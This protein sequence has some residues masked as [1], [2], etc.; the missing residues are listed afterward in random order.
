MNECFTRLHEIDAPGE[1]LT[2]DGPPCNFS[3]LRSLGAKLG[4]DDLDPSFIHPSDPAKK[5]HV[6]LDPCHMVKLLR[7]SFGDGLIFYTPDG[8]TIRWQYIEE[9]IKLQA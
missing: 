7:N 2:C 5:V 3:M 9:L 4:V 1:S 8:E 6:L